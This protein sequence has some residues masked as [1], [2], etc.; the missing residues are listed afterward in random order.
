MAGLLVGSAVGYVIY[1]NNQL[2]RIHVAN[3]VT[4]GSSPIEDILLI[5]STDRCTLDS[6]QGGAFGL[7]SN[8]VTGVNSDVVMVLR[9]NGQTET[10]VLTL[11]PVE[12][13]AKPP[14]TP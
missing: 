4:V 8:G 6:K 10:H 9:L 13:A 7:C 11:R 14:A 2:H 1:R 3:L 12:N 5:G